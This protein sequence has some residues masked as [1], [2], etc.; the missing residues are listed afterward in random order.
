MRAFLLWGVVSDGLPAERKSETH[1]DR[2]QY[3]HSRGQGPT[4]AVRYARGPLF[5]ILLG[6]LTTE[7]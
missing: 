1:C 7:V 6:V 4:G 3:S 2:H 5:S